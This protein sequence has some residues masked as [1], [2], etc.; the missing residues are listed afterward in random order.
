M[1]NLK[2]KEEFYKNLKT[3]HFKFEYLYLNYDIEDSKFIVDILNYQKVMNVNNVMISG[4]IYDENILNIVS[5]YT[6][7]FEI[8]KKD[9]KINRFIKR[10]LFIINK[11]E[12]NLEK[13]LNNTKELI[14]KYLRYYTEKDEEMWM[15]LIFKEIIMYE[16]LIEQEEKKKREKEWS[17]FLKK[18]NQLKEEQTEEELEIEE[19]DEL[20]ENE[21]DLFKKTIQNVYSDLIMKLRLGIL[22]DY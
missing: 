11:V 16:D 10:L 17:N 7:P 1:N 18:L 13:E 19:N 3:F 9:T 15:C 21:K 20:T 14:Q 5:E 4:N 2:N 12:G 6:N 22:D 8:L